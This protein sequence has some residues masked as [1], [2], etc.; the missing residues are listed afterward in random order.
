[1]LIHKL[2]ILVLRQAIQDLKVWHQAGFD[3][4]RI[5]VNLSAVQLRKSKLTQKVL[6]SCEQAGVAPGHLEL[7]ITESA[8]V[9]NFKQTASVMQAMS[10]A[11]I[12]FVLDD[13]GKGFSSLSYL[14]TLP[15]DAIKIDHSFIEDTL[16][17][18]YDQ[19][20]I[21]GI[22]SLARGLHLRVTAEGVE[23]ESQKKVLSKLGCDE[24]QGT[25]YCEPV[26]MEQALSL[27]ES[28][29]RPAGGQ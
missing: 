4:L 10:E 27:L 12:H 6:E 28:H 2:G 15:I 11:G 3:D 21:N 29:N 20:I 9:E 22:I 26:A 17:S 14:R 25:L 23:T 18:E 5:A 1:G 8:L 7:E 19:T 16:P 24:V 13:F